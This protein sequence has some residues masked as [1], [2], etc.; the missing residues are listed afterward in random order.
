MCVHMCAIVGSIQQ[1]WLL[2]QVQKLT[3]RNDQLQRENDNL[4]KVLDATAE[5]Q[6]LVLVCTDC[7]ARAV[8]DEHREEWWVNSDGSTEVGQLGEQ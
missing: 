1:C 8:V 5:V 7:I 4:V 6:L 2:D 3:L